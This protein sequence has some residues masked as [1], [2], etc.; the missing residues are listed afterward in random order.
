MLKL[1]R[2]PRGTNRNRTLHRPPDAPFDDVD[3]AVV[4]D[5]FRRFWQQVRR[6]NLRESW[7]KGG[8]QCA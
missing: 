1:M 3:Y 8:T 6:S 4:D 7:D 2:L 5:L